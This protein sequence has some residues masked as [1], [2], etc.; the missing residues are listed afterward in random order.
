MELGPV[1]LIDIAILLLAF[2]LR[3]WSA[4]RV[5]F[6]YPILLIILGFIAAEVVVAVGWETGLRVS[7]FQTIVNYL[8]LPT[9][10]YNLSR[11]LRLNKLSGWWPVIIYLAMP[12]LFLNMLITAWV[13]YTGINSPEFTWEAAFITASILAATCSLAMLDVFERFPCSDRVKGIIRGEALLGGI[14]AVILFK[15]FLDLVSNPA[16]L[17]ASSGEWM[18]EFLQQIFG[19]AFVG[20]MVGGLALGLLI[21]NKD[22]ALQTFVTI[23]AV[24]FSYIMAQDILHCSGVFAVATVGITFNYLA[25]PLEA[26]DTSDFVGRVWDMTNLLAYTCLFLLLG[27]TL[28]PDMFSNNWYPMLVGLVGSIIARAVGIFVILPL[29]SLLR[30]KHP[31]TWTERALIYLGGT[32]GAV[33]IVLVFLL[34]LKLPYYATVQAIVFGVVIGTILLKV[35]VGTLLVRKAT[36]Q[37]KAKA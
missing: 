22:P 7:N 34:P 27:V 11:E 30:L 4:K 3:P 13:L 26:A 12:I 37:P 36:P 31:L 1:P 10:I 9:I 8:F 20:V 25:R 6:T 15:L 29:L 14:F 33:T 35:P 21:I 32:R 16:M 28:T 2:F 24:Y 19:G 23:A 5:V 18:G 17:E